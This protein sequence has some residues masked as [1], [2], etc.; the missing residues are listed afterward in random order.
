MFLRRLKT[1]VLMILDIKIGFLI[2]EH[3]KASYGL[4]SISTDFTQVVAGSLDSF[5]MIWDRIQCFNWR[6]I[7][8]IFKYYC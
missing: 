3:L 1:A 4:M 6:I 8:R 5:A 2:V 7:E